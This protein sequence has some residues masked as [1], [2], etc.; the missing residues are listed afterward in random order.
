MT[1]A[2]AKS[3][4]LSLLALFCAE[5]ANAGDL[6]VFGP[7][8]MRAIET[9]H[10]GRKFIV[11]IWSTDCPPCRREL[12]LLGTFS[13][14]HPNLPVVLIATDPPDNAEV[15]RG[16][17]ASFELPRA[18]FWLFGD[19]G[20]ERLRYTIDSEWRGEMPR[21]Y[22]YG[23]DGGRLGI[24]GPISADFLERW[25]DGANTATGR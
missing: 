3:A 8:D 25:L 20:A 16:V 18:D 12:S 4:L 23:A 21:T 13:A 11:A 7:A 9:A 5:A 19:A 6:R 2:V 22:L 14:D 1:G 17:L 24:S 15:V 10:A